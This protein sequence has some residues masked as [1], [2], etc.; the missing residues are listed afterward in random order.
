MNEKTY[1]NNKINELN[2]LKGDYQFLTLTFEPCFQG[3]HTII[4]N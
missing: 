4:R 1:L 2:E 3:P